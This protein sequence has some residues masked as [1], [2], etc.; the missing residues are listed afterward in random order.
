M[1]RT[2]WAQF[3]FVPL[4]TGWHLAHHVDSEVPY[5]NLPK[6]QREL[7]KARY[8]PPELIWPSYRAL[9]AACVSRRPPHPTA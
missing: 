5:R 6:L 4:N 1:H 7:D 8:C 9:W 2:F 3:W